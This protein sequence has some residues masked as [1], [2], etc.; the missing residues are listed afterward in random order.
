V[1]LS[2]VVA[3]PPRQ[4]GPLIDA[5]QNMIDQNRC[6]VRVLIDMKTFEG[7]EFINNY[8]WRTIQF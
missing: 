4:R 7:A 3:L 6:V 8:P 5:F 1:K 2:E